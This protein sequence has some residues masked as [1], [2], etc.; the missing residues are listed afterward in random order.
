MNKNNKKPVSKWIPFS[1]VVSVFSFIST[2]TMCYLAYEANHLT[3]KANQLSEKAISESMRIAEEANSLAKK[4]NDKT[5]RFAVINAEVQWDDI[6][7]S[8]GKIDN[9]LQEW[10]KT[11]NL[12]RKGEIIK[13]RNELE[14]ELSQLDAPDYIKRLYLKRFDKYQIMKN[15]AEQYK[16]F[17]QRMTHI[18]YTLPSPPRLPPGTIL[19]IDSGKSGEAILKIK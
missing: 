16:P 13:S 9:S 8:Y 1:V 12:K 17:S 6:W 3:Y 10:E 2:L 19:K 14:M 18:D 15:L 11:K 7:D 5:E 4:A